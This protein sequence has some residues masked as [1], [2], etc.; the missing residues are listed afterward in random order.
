VKPSEVTV[1]VSGSVSGREP[2]GEDERED[3]ADERELLMRERD[4]G[5][6]GD[7]VDDVGV[8][9]RDMA[10]RLSERLVEAEIRDA[11]VDDVV[12]AFFDFRVDDIRRLDSFNSFEI[13]CDEDVDDGRCLS[14]GLRETSSPVMFLPCKAGTVKVTVTCDVVRLLGVELI[15]L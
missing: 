12:V 3:A 7:K 5:A 10:L 4:E 6:G 1:E 11:V 8:E 14:D 13:E 9:I 2:D 15:W